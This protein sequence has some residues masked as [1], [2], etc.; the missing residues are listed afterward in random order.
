ME[1]NAFKKVNE[2]EWII[3][4]KGDMR[5]PGII[6]A[7]ESIIRDLDE[8]VWEQ[9][10]NVATLPGIQKASMAMPDAHWGYGFPIGGVAAFDPKEEGIIS[11]GGVGYDI[12]CLTPDA[13]IM[14][15][16]GCWKKIGEMK[17]DSQETLVSNS[18]MMLKEFS[19][20][21]LTLDKGEIKEKTA[22]YFMELDP[23]SQ[24]VEV[25][26]STGRRINATS[27]HPFLTPNGMKPAETLKKGDLIAVYPFEGV[28]YEPCRDITI[29]GEHNILEGQAKDSLVAR[30]L[31][32]LTENN[33]KLPLITKI[34][35]YLFGD[36]LVYFSG[37][38][39][40]IHAY[41]QEEDLKT[42]A[43]DIKKLGYSARIY[44]RK[45]NHK[46][47]DQYGTKEFLSTS[48]ELHVRST[49]LAMLF[50]E[51]GMPVGNK[52]N[53]EY[54]VPAWLL[55]APKWIKRLFLAG[56]FGAEMSTPKNVS[57]T[58][59]YC[60]VVSQ[61]KVAGALGS[62][63]RF[64]QEVSNMLEEFGVKTNKI[65]VRKEYK[66]KHR[67]RL[68]LSS[69]PESLIALWTRVGF[70]Y[71]RKR[72]EEGLAAAQYLKEKKEFMK[73]RLKAAVR[74][75]EYKAKG[76]SLKEAIKDLSGEHANSRFIER[77]YYS[78]EEKFPRVSENFIS[79]GEWRA[80][81]PGPVFWEQV[82]STKALDYKGKVYDL[83]VPGTHNFVANGFV[84]SNCG[85]RTIKTDLKKEDLKPKL[86]ELMEELFRTVPAGLGSEGKITLTKDQEDEMLAKG[87]RWAVEQGYG[88]KEDLEYTE[89]KGTAPD[90]DP[91]KVSDLA[92]K[93]EKKQAGT[94]GSGN[95]YLEVQW[96]EEVY[97]PEIARIYGLEKD[98][99]V[100]TFHCG[101]RGLGHQVASDYMQILDQAAPEYGIKLPD[102]Q[103]ACA[104][105]ESQE[106]KDYWQ[107]MNA[108]INN[109]LSNR[110]VIA[111]LTRKAFNKVFPDAELPQLYDTSH[112]TCRKEE[113]TVNGTKKIVYVHRKGATSALGPGRPELPRSYMNAGQP[114]LIGGTMGT[115]SYILAGTEKGTEKA[116]GSACHGAGRRMSRTQAKKTW[117]GDR[118]IQDL[119]NSGI[120]VKAHSFKGAAEEAPGAY[121]DV[122]QVVNAVHN[123]GLA[124]KVVRVRPL[125]V[126]KG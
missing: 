38:K 26:S 65:S 32:P 25:T 52:T 76:K 103:L 117:K 13:K 20:R 75:K 64:M 93:R 96:V 79:F 118:V 61:N 115:Y 31:L 63:I 37:N 110:Q 91:S 111:H 66:N 86:K 88:T 35:G 81:N 23:K 78:K 104:P 56:F 126:V 67:V 15:E 95:H 43:K 34:L 113:H 123:A 47:T 114:V 19:S 55:S 45:R 99:V 100:I 12:S 58:N 120:I 97:D 74:T 85:V 70:E 53:Q 122:R 36:G 77:H 112:N 18:N 46:I 21:T 17:E 33:T 29:V 92:K 44:S 24:V 51:I 98:Q 42:I 39:G 125:G 72:L 124:K 69:E 119:A 106:G 9:V 10:S 90:A 101:S 60:P 49:S 14:I 89:M 62:G 6:F 73:K 83:T 22:S 84:V 54:S 28:E 121:K 108:A 50:K 1:P 109:A 27:D 68:I 57:R 11:A 80:K 107:A 71:N 116:F 8:K 40:Y 5:V 16:H 102:R 94:L 82:E 48:H 30:N 105:I 41:G 87:A 2:Y 3:P 59:F 4:Q 7:D